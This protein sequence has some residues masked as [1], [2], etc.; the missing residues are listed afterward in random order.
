MLGYS[1]ALGGHQLFLHRPRADLTGPLAV[2]LSAPRGPLA[3]GRFCPPGRGNV[4]A[5]HLAQFTGVSPAQIYLI[6]AAVQAETD[7]FVG[8]L[9]LIE[10]IDQGHGNASHHAIP[11]LSAGRVVNQPRVLLR[12][13]LRTGSGHVVREQE[14]GAVHPAWLSSPVISLLVTLIYPGWGQLQR[15]TRGQACNGTSRRIETQ[16]RRN[17]LTPSGGP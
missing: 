4:A 9:G 14:A 1:P 16:S 17:S 6:F 3:N 5:G 13:R 15:G 7:R 8:G 11:L 12:V 2:G 10:V